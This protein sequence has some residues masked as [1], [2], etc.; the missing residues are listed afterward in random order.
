MK[1]AYIVFSDRIIMLRLRSQPVKVNLIQVH[2]PTTD[3]S[4]NIAEDFYRPLD[5]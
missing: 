2:A 1:Q 3:K 4:E 5:R